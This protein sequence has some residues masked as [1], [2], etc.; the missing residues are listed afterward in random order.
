M[1]ST[2]GNS[3]SASSVS[4]MSEISLFCKNIINK[5][6]FSKLPDNI[7][8]VKSSVAVQSKLV[9]EDIPNIIITIPAFNEE[10]TI[11]KV[12]KNIH[13]FL[14]DSK[15]GEN[16]LVVVVNDGSDDKTVQIASNA[17]AYVFSHKK[18]MGLAET[19]RTEM[20]LCCELGAEI[21]VH[22]DADGQY[23]AEEITKL[24][25]EIENGHDLVLGSRFKGT[26]ESMTW[27]KKFGNMA[28]S[29]VISMLTLK[30][31][32]DAQTGFRAF[33]KEIAKEIQIISDHTYTQEQIITASKQ[34][35]CIKEV[36]VFFA[37]R[38]DGQSRLMKNP[39]E[40]ALKAWKNLIKIILQ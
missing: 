30:R 19:F 31:I 38:E 2:K 37:K 24:I 20:K 7:V 39:I 21:I 10:K 33:S 29:V 32:S 3:E 12:I 35:Y 34:K 22:T 26:I 17:G 13:L 1:V 28:F 11:G 27:L 14:R 15:Y 36:P 40:Y 6:H 23:K 16:Y 8:G 4:N 5:N 9:V 18:N 25:H